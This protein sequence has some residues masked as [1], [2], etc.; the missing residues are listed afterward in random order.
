MKILHI[1]DHSIPLHSGYTFR[2]RAILENQRA[3]GLQ[4][5]HLTSPKQGRTDKSKEQVEGL[6]FYRCEGVPGW[7]Q[8]IPFAN[9]LAI[10]PLLSRRIAEVI[11]QERPDI[12]HA[13]S[14]ALNGVAA[15]H[16]ARKASL[17]LVYEVRAFWEDAA[18]NL[19]TSSEGGM[20][21]RL[22]RA[23]ETHVLKRA[24]AVTCICHGLRQDII[25]RGVPAQ[26]ITTIPNAV[27][28]EQFP[29]LIGKS[30]DILQ[31]HSLS[32]QPVIGFIGSFYEYEGL[33][34]L[35]QAVAKLRAT[36]PHLRVLLVGGGPQENALKQLACDLDVK[37]QIIFT[38]R[39]PHQDVPRYYSVLDA[40]VYPR[41]SMRLTELVTPLK[42]MEAMAQGKPVLASDVGGHKELITHG[43][44]GYLFAA[45]NPAALASA[46]E[47]MFLHTTSDESLVARGR[48]F[49]E[50]ERNWVASVGRYHPIY[51]AIA[52]ACTTDGV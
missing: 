22:T 19:G 44:N 36:L 49:V 38:G 42:P 47:S 12:I 2:S 5:C 7:I 45:N 35:I 20:R 31:L 16:A 37:D 26:R 13:H 39:V 11:A 14:P 30:A 1:F 43:E 46:L 17:P 10:I 23:L 9:Q 50:Q 24:D 40:L 25:A 41:K 51:A 21:Y 18:V 4:T 52:G 6:D 32:D 29:L 28:L 48:E 8:A 3:Q 33:D 27:D 15:L 34:I